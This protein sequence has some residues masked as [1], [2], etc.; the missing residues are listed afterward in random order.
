MRASLSRECSNLHYFYHIVGWNFSC[1]IIYSY[2]Y[3][4]VWYD[5]LFQSSTA[6]MLALVSLF[7][8]AKE[9]QYIDLTML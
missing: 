6:R 8:H 9:P 5:T 1:S 7:Q 3:A 4:I 2:N